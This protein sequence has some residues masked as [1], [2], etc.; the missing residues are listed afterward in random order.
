MYLPYPDQLESPRLR[1]RFVTP[2][3]QVPWA[4]FFKDPEAVALFPDAG[5]ASYAER[6]ERWIERQLTRY[7]EGRFGM[8]VLLEKTTGAFVGQCGLLAQEVD[9]VAELEVGY[10]VFRKYWG[11]GYAPEAARLFI[12]L[13]FS[14]YLA[15]SVIS[16]IDV[17][18][19][20]SQRVAE[21][22]GLQREKQTRWSDLDV[23]I[24]RI[25]R[26]HWK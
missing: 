6:A 1:T 26:P 19:V 4:D 16:I 17:R 15:D 25:E 18:N 24:Y 20:N 23:Y 8:Q 12:D 22:N 3:D 5:S 11:Q 7:R 10:H 21:K 9:G 13:A 14:R 2:A